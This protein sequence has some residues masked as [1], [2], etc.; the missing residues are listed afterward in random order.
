[1]QRAHAKTQ[2]PA[3]TRPNLKVTGELVPS[4]EQPALPQHELKSVPSGA[5][6]F[7]GNRRQHHRFTMTRASKI[8]RR[9]SNTFVPAQTINL[10][11]GGALIEA[12]AARPFEPGEIVDVGVALRP[13][14]AGT[15]IGSDAMVQAIVV[16]VEAIDEHRQSVAL[17]Y[18][19]PH[20]RPAARAA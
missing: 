13:T 14:N 1:M 17:R 8:Y 12:A 10:S 20:H 5:L 16:R 11:V 4:S 19:N 9:A 7:G 6:L 2:S 15:V 3:H 18:L